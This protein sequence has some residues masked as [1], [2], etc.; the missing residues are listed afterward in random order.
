[1]RGS[2]AMIGGGGADARLLENIR[3]LFAQLQEVQRAGTAGNAG[4]GLQIKNTSGGRIIGGTVFGISAAT[5]NLTAASADEQN[6]VRPVLV[7]PEAVA[8]S[9]M[10]TPAG[11]GQAIKVRTD[12]T[13]FRRGRLA[14][15]SATRAGTVT[16][17]APT[18][19]V[20]IG[21]VAEA[22]ENGLVKV[23]LGIGAAAA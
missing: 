11:A 1:M 3:S 5:G 15:L 14:W 21:T 12:G 6:F 9:A 22:A 2:A 13:G 8:I 10:F 19:R 20:A 23:I 4:M 18:R 7:A 17:T 16:A